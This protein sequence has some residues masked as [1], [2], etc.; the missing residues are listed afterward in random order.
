MFS[1]MLEVLSFTDRRHKL[2]EKLRT[3]TSLQQ[4]THTL[5][6][7]DGSKELNG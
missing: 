4:L 5:Q 6:L 3:A 1:N 2:Q 7:K